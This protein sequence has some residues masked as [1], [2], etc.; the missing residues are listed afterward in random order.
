MD[1]RILTYFVA[2]VESKSI[3][4]AANHLHVTQPTLSRQIK[5]LE[6]DLDTI[7]FHRGSRE[8]QLT[9]DGQYLYN[10][11]LEIL[12]LVEKT[13]GNL[14]KSD[15]YSGDI[16]IGAAEIPSFE[17]L[18]LAVSEM[19]RQYPQVKFHLHSG[20]AQDIFERIDSGILDLGLVIGD[21]DS[22]K[23][24]GLP[25]PMTERWGVLT[26]TDHPFAGKS[27]VNLKDVTDYP[28]I[29]S[30]QANHGQH[31]LQGLGD[32]T[33]VA[34]YNLLYNASLLVKTGLGIAITIEGILNL[35]DTELSFTP[36]K[37]PNTDGLH[38]IW[39]KSVTQ[40]RLSKKLLDILSDK[41]L[42][43]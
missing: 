4:H 27:E 11:A 22:R 35:T 19:R 9:E 38:I 13:Q 31:Y 25:M 10:R 14:R 29:L 28:L 30:A 6:E 41:Y 36:V 16:S 34:T 43:A 37:L 21:F 7:L 12:A 26:R 32:Y 40:N 15:A 23:Y 33:V 5:D 3:S 42:P 8:I 18:A 24:D 2:I 20:N 17:P 1:I 39:K